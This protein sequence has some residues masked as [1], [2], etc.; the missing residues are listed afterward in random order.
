MTLLELGVGD[1]AADDDGAG[2]E[3]RSGDRVLG[4]LGED[5]LHRPVQVDPHAVL[6]LSRGMHRG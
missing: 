1:V 6:V 5:F 3:E 2:E 4:E